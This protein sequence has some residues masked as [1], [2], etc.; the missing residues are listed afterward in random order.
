MTRFDYFRALNPDKGYPK[1]PFGIVSHG[2]KY[3]LPLPAFVAN[4]LAKELSYAGEF[5]RLDAF[6]TPKGVN[7]VRLTPPAFD[8]ALGRSAYVESTL[9]LDLSQNEQTMGCV[10]EQ[11]ACNTLA[12][13]DIFRFAMEGGRFEADVADWIL[14]R[15]LFFLHCGGFEVDRITYYSDLEEKNVVDTC[16]NAAKVSQ[17]PK[18][19]QKK[20]TRMLRFRDTLNT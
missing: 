10:M 13:A 1:S 17:E 11:S 2:I 3:D 8:P 16:V 4:A 15:S 19:I 7:V 20:S 6:C 5:Y 9:R 12:A 14:N 18:I